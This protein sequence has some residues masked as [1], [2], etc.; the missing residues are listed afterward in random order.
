MV[1]N[2]ERATQSKIISSAEFKQSRV[3]NIRVKKSF[4]FVLLVSIGRR[5]AL[6]G[7]EKPI[8]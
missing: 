8:P 7:E 5:A 6:R 2:I 3:E 1:A 4:F